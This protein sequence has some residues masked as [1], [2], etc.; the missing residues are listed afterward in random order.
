MLSNKENA[1]TFFQAISL[2]IFFI[3][4]GAMSEKYLLVFYDIL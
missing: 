3:C 2:G 1:G 4:F